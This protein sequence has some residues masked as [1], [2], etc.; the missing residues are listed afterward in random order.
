[1]SWPRWIAA[2]SPWTAAL[3]DAEA[4]GRILQELAEPDRNP[5]SCGAL[6][7]RLVPR[8]RA[9]IPPPRRWSAGPRRLEV[10]RP[11]LIGSLG[12]APADAGAPGPGEV[13]IDV[14][15][16]AL[17]FRDVMWAQGLLPDEALLDGFSGP[18]LGLECAGVVTALGE[19]VDDLRPGDR[20]IAVAPAALATHV[21]TRRNGVMR[22]PPA[23]AFAAAA[24]IPVAFMTAVY[25]LGHAG[26]AGGGRARAD[27]RRRRRRRPRRH[28][29]CPA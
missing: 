12:W 26:P 21:V 2:P 11:G 4:A 15:A 18:S 10:A 1:M 5:R 14:H 3:P 13:A 17:N 28:P 9:G 6:G 22:M 19:G 7:G 8:L 20:V 25:A 16:A 27:P 24:T 29:V 23:I